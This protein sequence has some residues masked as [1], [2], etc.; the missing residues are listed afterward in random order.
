V[1][2]V[3]NECQRSAILMGLGDRVIAISDAVGRAMVSRGIS[4]SKLRVV[5]NGTL[6][7]ARSAA[8][9][10]KDGSEAALARPA[11]VTVAGMYARAEPLS[12]RRGCVRAGLT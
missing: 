7:T 8:V 6:G 4:P 11:L 10:V 2:T 1:T 5:R 12:S 9:K 3:H